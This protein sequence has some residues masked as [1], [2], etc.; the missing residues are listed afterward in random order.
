MA[1]IKLQGLAANTLSAGAHNDYDPGVAISTINRI[2]I[3]PNAGDASLTGL[4]A[5]L[6]GQLMLITNTDAVNNLTLSN[7]DAGSAAAN[8]FFGVASLTIPAGGS[9]L[10]CYDGIVLNRWVML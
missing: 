3:D 5:G 1:L 10:C 9:A 4:L 2:E 7:Q 8:R 6:D